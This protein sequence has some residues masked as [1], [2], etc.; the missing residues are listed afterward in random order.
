M[1]RLP[2]LEAHWVGKR[3]EI[4]AHTDRWMRGDR[5][6]V[7]QSVRRRSDKVVATIEMDKSGV[8]LRCDLDALK[9]IA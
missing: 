5:Y 4:P 3:V 6:G 2:H 7:V 8:R 9:E 1:P